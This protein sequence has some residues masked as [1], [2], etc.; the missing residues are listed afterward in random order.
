MSD[1]PSYPSPTPVS[2]S[3][4]NTL[5]IVSLIASIL[6]FLPIIPFIGSVVGVITGHMAK[7]QIRESM[8]AQTGEGM[9]T[10]GLIIGYITIGLYVCG[11]LV[12]AAFTVWGIITSSSPSY[13]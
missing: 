5:A 8:G 11:C 7:K 2:T 9:A 6:G 4:T 3:Q 1:Y 12:F 13:Y 10:A